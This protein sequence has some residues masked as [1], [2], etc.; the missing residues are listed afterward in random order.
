[1]AAKSS[2]PA[3]QTGCQKS[4]QSPLLPSAGGTSYYAVKSCSVFSSPGPLRASSYP[5]ALEFPEGDICL[6]KTKMPCVS[7][8]C[9]REQRHL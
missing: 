2:L 8:D 1:M 7:E 3:F 9:R 5:L 6:R 4:S